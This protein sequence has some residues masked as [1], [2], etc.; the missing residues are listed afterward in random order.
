[1]DRV[2]VGQSAHVTIVWIG[3]VW[4]TLRDGDGCTMEGEGFV[5]EVT[6]T[7]EGGR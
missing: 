1:M 2:K 4:F 7:L 3:R 6:E 5:L